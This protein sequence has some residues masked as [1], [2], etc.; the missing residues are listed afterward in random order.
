VKHTCAQLKKVSIYSH[1][2]RCWDCVENM[3]GQFVACQAVGAKRGRQ[4]F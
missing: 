3:E 4:T 1:W 2:S